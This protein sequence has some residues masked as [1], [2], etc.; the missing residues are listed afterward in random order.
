MSTLRPR[1]QGELCLFLLT[2]QVGQGAD[3]SMSGQ[4]GCSGHWWEG[5]GPISENGND[6]LPYEINFPCVAWPKSGGS[7]RQ[8][9]L[10]GEFSIF[11]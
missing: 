11:N 7:K 5:S 2:V 4:H 10:F 1:A 6:A 8:F 9:N 3:I